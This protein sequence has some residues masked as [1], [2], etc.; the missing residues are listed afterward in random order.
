VFLLLIYF[1]VTSSFVKNSAVKIDFPQSE[2]IETHESAISITISS[3]GKYFWD[4]EELL[5]AAEQPEKMKAVLAKIDG[6]FTSADTTKGRQVTL[7]LD[8]TVEIQYATPIMGRVA[9]YNGSVAFRTE[10]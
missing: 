3:D 7:N 5:P 2:S 10:K 8:K 1:M 9:A 6:Y 4:Q